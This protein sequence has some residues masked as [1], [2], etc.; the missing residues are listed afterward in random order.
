MDRLRSFFSGTDAGA[1]ARSN[2]DVLLVT[3]LPNIAYL[4]GFTGSS[5]VLLVEA[6][7]ATL[8]TD[9]R[10]TFQAREQV[11]N[12]KTEIVGGPLLDAVAAS[13]KRRKGTV[14]LGYSPSQVTVAQK[15]ALDAAVGT[16][17]RWVNAPNAVERLRAV[18]DSAELALMRD[19]AKLIDKVW[20]A[21]LR[22]VKVGVPELVI[23]AEIEYRMKLGGA[24]GA[25][26]ETIVASGKRSA[27][28]HARPTSKLL[29]KNE[30]VVMDQGAIL[31]GYC[32]DM[33]RT[34]F[35]GRASS[36]IRALYRAVLDSQEAA[37]A[38][39]RPGATAGDV[40]AAARNTLKQ[41]RLDQVFTHSTGH[42]LGTEVHEMP[43]LARGEETIL[44]KGMVITVEPGIYLEGFGGI[45]IEDDMVVTASGSESLTNAKRELIEL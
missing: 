17:L 40:D 35:L 31:R 33:T 7:A 44:E 11:F 23:A 9:S 25:S 2:I 18:K 43:R 5:G 21:A 1:P 36:R 13:L 12:A 3:H 27:W 28:A 19:A 34:V 24:S 29:R 6:S 4:C 8:F 32:S 15:L 30:L 42:G 10:Y 38:A 22:K 20:A 26:F 45:R 37:K 16:R 14:R 39:I 41:H